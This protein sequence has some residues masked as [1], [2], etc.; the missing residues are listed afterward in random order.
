M[1][2]RDDKVTKKDVQM[3]ADATVCFYSM[4]WTYM[5]WEPFSPFGC[6]TGIYGVN[7]YCSMCKM[8]GMT[9][10]VL[11]A[12]RRGFGY[13]PETEERD[14]FVELY[15]KEKLKAAEYLVELVKKHRKIK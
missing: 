6:G 7:W 14:R 10:A 11:C 5:D 3:V 8:Q 1:R 9:I 4:P 12:N 2:N 15:R 13:E